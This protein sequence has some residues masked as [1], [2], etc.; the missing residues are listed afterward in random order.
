MPIKFR[1]RWIPFIA[2]AVVVALGISLGQ[3]Q[4]RRAAEKEQIESKL[5]A[6]QSAPPLAIGTQS[7]AI[8]DVGGIDGLE[9]RRVVVRGE[10][11]RDWPVYLDNRPYQGASGFYVL[12]PLK[13]AGSDL[14]V[15]VARGWTRRD[16]VDRTK[17]MALAPPAGTVEIEGVAKRNSGHVMQLGRPEPLRPGAIVQ[18]LDIEEFTKGSKLAMQPFVIEQLTDTQ[19]KLV[20][21]WPRPSAGV[22]KHRGYAF[23]W[24]A[25][26][27]TAFLFFIVTGFR[28]ERK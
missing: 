26:A 7:R 9:Y 6:R 21:D 5:S 22:E 13:I 17:V 16:P 14:H 19:D 25:L 2:T 18:N 24:Y 23:Q 8:D 10:F 28:S 20:R 27:A 11:V 1:F 12:T 3:W 4:T 15:L